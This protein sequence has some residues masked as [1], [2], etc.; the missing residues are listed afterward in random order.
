MG[1]LDEV[2]ELEGKLEPASRAVVSLLR[3]MYEQQLET[4]KE[5]RKAAEKQ[6][7]TVTELTRTIEQL[8]ADNAELKQ[9]LFGRKSERLKDGKLPSIQSEVRRVVEMEEL[10]GLE[11][12]EGDKAALE[13]KPERNAETDRLSQK[14][15]RRRGRNKSEPERK[16]RRGLRRNL[17]VVRERVLVN[18]DQLPEGY[19]LKDFREMGDGEVIHRVEH[20]REHVVLVDYVLQTLVSKD[21]AHIVKASSLSS[22]VPEGPTST[23]IAGTRVLGGCRKGDV[24]PD[25]G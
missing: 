17:P 7:E 9:L 25:R 19:T 3:G 21:G 4:L 24:K 10:F 11:T 6:T 1:P 2:R 12:D 20:V 8:R 23:G 18:P 14:E 5:L 16:K 22:P 15:R 13:T